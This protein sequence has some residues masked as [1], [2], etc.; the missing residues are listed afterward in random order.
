MHPEVATKN[1]SRHC[2]IRATSLLS[3]LINTISLAYPVHHHHKDSLTQFAVSGCV[4]MLY[5]LTNYCLL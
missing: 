1:T 3:Y 2:K 5:Y 4:T